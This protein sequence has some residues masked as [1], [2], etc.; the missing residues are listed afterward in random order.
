MELMDSPRSHLSQISDFCLLVK[1]GS[2][3]SR[4]NIAPSLTQLL[5]CC[6]DPLNSQA[7]ADIRQIVFF[8]Y[9]A[10]MKTA[11][12][13]SCLS[14]PKFSFLRRNSLGLDGA[15]CKN[16]GQ[17]LH[18]NLFEVLLLFPV[19]AIPQFIYHDEP[20]KHLLGS[21]ILFLIVFTLCAAFL[22]FRIKT[23]I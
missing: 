1:K 11:N 5:K 23:K 21:I 3:T 2:G 8:Q 12:C 7:E 14:Q 18:C 16:C 6:D 9:N 15:A 19:I 10:S 4:H 13:P 17:I 22:P 20:A